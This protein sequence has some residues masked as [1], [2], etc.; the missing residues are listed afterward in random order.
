MVT[1]ERSIKRSVSIA[2]V[3]CPLAIR[4][5]VPMGWALAVKINW[6]LPL[7]IVL[8]TAIVLVFPKSM[9]TVSPLPNPLPATVIRVPICPDFGEIRI[10]CGNI[11]N[12]SES[13]KQEVSPITLTEVVP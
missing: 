13:L 8:V 7:T 5:V 6:K 1:E 9:A 12:Q 3:I 10:M 4:V 11:L 2:L